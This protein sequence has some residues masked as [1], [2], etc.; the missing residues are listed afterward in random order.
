MQHPGA[1]VTGRADL[2]DTPSEP[3]RWWDCRDPTFPIHV[4][5][6]R[7]QTM[8][9]SADGSVGLVGFPV[10][11]E[12]SGS[13]REFMAEEARPKPNTMSSLHYTMHQTES[14]Y[15]FAVATH[16]SLEKTRV[17][18]DEV[19]VD[20]YRTCAYAYVTGP[21]KKPGSYDVHDGPRGEKN[22]NR[23]RITLPRGADLERL[24]AA[25]ARFQEL[26]ADFSNNSL[27]ITIPKAAPAA[28]VPAPPTGEYVAPDETGLQKQRAA[29]RGGTD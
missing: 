14:A 15:V 2:H 5:R 25:G 27:T 11:K 13:W 12:W 3:H 16:W 20:A 21:E 29:A 24:R 17:D 19:T 23:G 28:T 9:A 1:C 7:H 8:G 6:A 22:L 10:Q 4:G 18:F 26:F